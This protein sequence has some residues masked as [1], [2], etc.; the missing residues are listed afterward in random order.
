M[1][2]MLERRRR[3]HGNNES[4]NEKE[5]NMTKMRP[6][7]LTEDLFEILNNCSKCQLFKQFLIKVIF[8]ERNPQ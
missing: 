7:N 3:S 2:K 1:K 4:Y 8:L 5:T 6:R